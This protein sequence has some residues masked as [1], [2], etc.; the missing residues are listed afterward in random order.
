MVSVGDLMHTF[1][2]TVLLYLFFTSLINV[3]Q[4]TVT[5]NIPAACLNEAINIDTK[6]LQL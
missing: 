6:L 1:Q 4:C 3:F 2:V 5:P